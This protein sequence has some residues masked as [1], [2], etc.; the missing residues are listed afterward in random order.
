MVKTKGMPVFQV[1][2]QPRWY[3]AIVER[4]VVERAL[5]FLPSN[6]G[7]VF[8]VSTEDVW[9]LHGDRL[10]RGVGGRI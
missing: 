10:R 1:K 4:G 6:A 3:S 8:V 2:V 9:R 5:Q 7:K